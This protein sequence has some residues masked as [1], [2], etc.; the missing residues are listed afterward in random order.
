MHNLGDVILKDPDIAGFGS[1]TGSTG[2]AQSANTGRFFIVLKPRNERKLSASQIIDR[3][4]PQLAAVK[5]ATVFLQAPQDITVGG[6]LSR[7]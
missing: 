3:L 7:G 6:R 5:G 2:S 1:Q 4:R